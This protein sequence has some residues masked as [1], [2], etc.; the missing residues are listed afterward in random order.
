[1]MG[2]SIEESGAQ[3]TAAVTAA[4]GRPKEEGNAGRLRRVKGKISKGSMEWGV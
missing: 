1:M 3:S 4:T 2:E